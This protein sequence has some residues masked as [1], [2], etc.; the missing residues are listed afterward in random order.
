MRW[1]QAASFSWSQRKEANSRADGAAL[2]HLTVYD[3]CDNTTFTKTGL[4]SRE[5][6]NSLLIHCVPAGEDSQLEL[7]LGGGA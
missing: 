3:P 5:N 1:D 4:V 7:D 6:T 2:V